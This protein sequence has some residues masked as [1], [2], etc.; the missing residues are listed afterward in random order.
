M[1]YFLATLPLWGLIAL[2]VVLPAA[3]AIAANAL[4]RRRVDAER[5]A[6]SNEIDAG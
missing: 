6:Q 2:V 1:S 5:L 3:V 4:I